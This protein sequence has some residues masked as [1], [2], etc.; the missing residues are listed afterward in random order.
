MGRALADAVAQDP[1]LRPLLS[2]DLQTLLQVA[3]S[4]EGVAALAA[5]A[6]RTAKTPGSGGSAGSGAAGGGYPTQVPAPEGASA[7][8]KVAA[9]RPL[10]FPAP[11]APDAATRG[12]DWILA[13]YDSW[14]KLSGQAPRNR[15]ALGRL[16]TP[17]GYDWE[18]IERVFKAAAATQN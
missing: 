16:L 8:E 13:A 4:P 9:V 10:A 5:V 15:D 7:D 3:E 12:K 18:E 6:A 11:N 14:F 17:E 1:S 2:P